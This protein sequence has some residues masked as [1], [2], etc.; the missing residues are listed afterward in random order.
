MHPAMLTVSWA[1]TVFFRG[2]FE[3][4]RDLSEID[5]IQWRNG[6]VNDNMLNTKSLVG[7][8]VVLNEVCQV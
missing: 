8:F 5:I 2:L 6:R 3:W 1:L 7:E 4:Y